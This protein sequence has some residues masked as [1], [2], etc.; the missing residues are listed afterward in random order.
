MAEI[1]V[2]QTYVV[3]KQRRNLSAVS[4]KFGY[5]IFI[6]IQNFELLIQSK[7]LP[8]GNSIS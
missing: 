1:A 3:E 7:V 6:L 4:C 5:S 8:D 2:S